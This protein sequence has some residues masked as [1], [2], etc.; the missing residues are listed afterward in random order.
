MKEYPM[1]VL[2]KKREEVRKK[3]LKVYDFS[4]GDVNEQVPEFIRKAL[5]ETVEKEVIR[6][7]SVRGKKELREVISNWLKK[8]F[9]VSR[10]PETQIIPTSGSKEA[11]FHFPLVFL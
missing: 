3:G 9:G 11:I 2:L 4:T 1:E 5:T 6:Y 7:P 8:R 10:D